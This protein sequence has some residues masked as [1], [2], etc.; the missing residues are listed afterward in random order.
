MELCIARV[1]AI[2]RPLQP[3]ATEAR[4]GSNAIRNKDNSMRQWER[5]QLERVKRIR[6][7]LFYEC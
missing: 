3:L 2:Q 6:E 5:L 4:A 7:V 1:T